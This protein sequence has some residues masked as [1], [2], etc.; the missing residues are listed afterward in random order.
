MCVSLPPVTLLELSRLRKYVE[1][2]R[3]IAARPPLGCLLEAVGDGLDGVEHCYVFANFLD[4]R[5]VAELV[6]GGWRRMRGGGG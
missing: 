1:L 3:E 6:R 2:E 5:L 4:V